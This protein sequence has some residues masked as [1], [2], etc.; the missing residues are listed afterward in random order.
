MLKIA[1]VEDDKAMA[2]TLKRHIETFSL[3]KKEVLSAQLFRTTTDFL[4]SPLMFDIV[5]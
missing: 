5:F 1:I 4:S 3:E 2:E